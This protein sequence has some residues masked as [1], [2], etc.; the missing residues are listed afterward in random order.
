LKIDPAVANCPDPI[1]A[2][3]QY[4]KAHRR[5]HTQ[6]AGSITKTHKFP[7]AGVSADQLEAGSPGSIPT[8]KGLPTSKRYKY[9]NL[10]IDHFSKYVHLT[11]HET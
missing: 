8:T 6:D 7:G 9:F 1:C 4:G 10:W 3:C 5:S 2:A 11:F